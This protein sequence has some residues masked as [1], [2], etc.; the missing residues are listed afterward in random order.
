[1]GLVMF[2]DAAG[3]RWRVW[4]VE[5]PTAR[6]HLMDASY[7]NGWLVFEKEDGSERRRL[8]QVPEDWA[9]LT[10]EH[11]GRLC[12]LGVTAAPV[13]TLSTLTT[14]KMPVAPRP[15]DFRQER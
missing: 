10:P 9:H 5:T 15:A 12:A 3:T 4:H 7:R 2:R 11:L 8:S 14:V 1:V 6:A 13:R